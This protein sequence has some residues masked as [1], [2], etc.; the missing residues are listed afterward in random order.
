VKPHDVAN[1]IVQ[2][3]RKKIEIDYGMEAFGKI[4]KKRRQIALMRDGLA[5]FQKGLKLS[6][7]VVEGRGGRQLQRDN[8][9]VRHS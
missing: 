6:P 1:G 4:V 9:G 3:K 7:G 8:C 2:R 5:D